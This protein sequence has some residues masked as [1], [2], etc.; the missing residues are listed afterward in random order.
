MKASSNTAA[1]NAGRV[2]GSNHR[3]HR[4]LTHF[5]Q[6]SKFLTEHQLHCGH[7][8]NNTLSLA[9]RDIWHQATSTH[10]L[11]LDNHFPHESLGFYSLGI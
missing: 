4:V 6:N 7:Y 8:V 9:Q 2:V 5:K 11:C 3:A 10:Q 1:D